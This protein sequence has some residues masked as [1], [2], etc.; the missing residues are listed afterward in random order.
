MIFS[1]LICIKKKCPYRLL[2]I[3]YRSASIAALQPDAAAVIACLYRGSATS[4]A[5][6]TP[7][8]LYWVCIQWQGKIHLWVNRNALHALCLCL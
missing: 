7:S 8:M 4:P 1:L 6:N 2:F 3:R 5:A